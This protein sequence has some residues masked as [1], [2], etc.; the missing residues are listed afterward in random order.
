MADMLPAKKPLL[1]NVTERK[2]GTLE[3]NLLI[4]QK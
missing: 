1:E 4:L 2:E 3:K